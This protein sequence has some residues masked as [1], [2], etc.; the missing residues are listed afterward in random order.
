MKHQILHTIYNIFD[1]WNSE[2]E[3]ACQ[4]GCSGCCSQ[5][6]TITA[7]EGEDILRYILKENK[8]SWLVD[9]RLSMDRIHQRA[10]MTTNDFAKACLDG[11]DLDPGDNNNLAPCPFLDNDLCGIYP[12]RPF[13]CRLFT[14]STTCSARQPAV[15]SD[16]YIEAATAISQLVE[17]LGQK[18]YWGNMLDVVPSLLDISDF[19]EIAD[20][21]NTTMIMQARMQTFTAKP[22]P[23]FL[24][25]EEH[26][27]EI[28]PLLE[29]IFNA[30][31][32]GKRIE[33]ILNGK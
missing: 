19:K 25:S 31:V 20:H 32:E 15:V 24:I 13:G 10:R 21:L 27:P 5:N 8:I 11:K 18:E 33:D 1:Q 6:V 7:L 2:Q 17:H 29:A 9:E 23:G 28:S 14:S 4:K 3:K 22:L 30:E 16:A 12:A 26:L